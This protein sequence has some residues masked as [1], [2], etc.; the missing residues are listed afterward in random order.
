METPTKVSCSTS[1][2][3]VSPETEDTT[4]IT[5]P[6]GCKLECELEAKSRTPPRLVLKE[7]QKLQ[8]SWPLEEI[9]RIEVT[10]SGDAE[11]CVKF[12]LRSN[13]ETG[14]L[15]QK[16]PSSDDQGLRTA[17]EQG[18]LRRGPKLVYTQARDARLLFD[19][20]RQRKENGDKSLQHL[21]LSECGDE[22]LA[23][24]DAAGG[25]AV[26]A[27]LGLLS[28]GGDGGEDAILPSTASRQV[29]AASSR[30]ESSVASALPSTVELL[31]FACSPVENQLPETGSEAVEVAMATSWGTAV[32]ISYGGSAESLR[33]ELAAPN[34]QRV[35]RFLF[36]GHANVPAGSGADGPGD[37]EPRALSLGFTKP[38]GLMENIEPPSLIAKL[39]G[40]NS[41]G[42]QSSL[43]LVVLN[44]CDSLALGKAIHAEGV[45]IVVCWST[46]VLDHG[47]R[48]FSTVFFEHV[49]GGESA[50]EAFENAKLAVELCTKDWK[51]REK[52]P[53]TPVYT[54]ADPAADRRP[55]RKWAVGVPVLIEDALQDISASSG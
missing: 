6:Q 3:S 2:L 8:L 28:L 13:L 38:G 15:G 52:T 26:G 39:L 20:L 53:I 50:R 16:M 44:G 24:D 33:K 11:P 27:A 31:I 54:L 4:F 23:A 36:C 47:A 14:K 35:R 25:D 48:I 19:A 43:E 7:R 34:N 51:G 10:T 9:S 12:W 49:A 30:S 45:P 22:Q 41:V 32:K 18:A 46:K 21:E 42:Q 1:R 5:L 37:G 29:S 40:I 17:Y 55:G